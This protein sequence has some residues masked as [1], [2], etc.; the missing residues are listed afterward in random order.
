MS[1]TYFPLWRM[2]KDLNVS[3]T[4]LDK[5]KYILISNGLEYLRIDINDVIVGDTIDSYIDDC[6]RKQVVDIVLNSHLNDSQK[7]I[8]SKRYGIFDGRCRTLDEIAKEHGVTRERIRQKE[9]KALRK[10]RSPTYAKQF[11][12]LM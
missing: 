5:L 9:A 2:L 11:K 3:K 4:K 1:L 6:C 12:E 10:L 7:D 8:L